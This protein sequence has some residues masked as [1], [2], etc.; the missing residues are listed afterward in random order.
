MFKT[1]HNTEK[2]ET[3]SENQKIKELSRINRTRRTLKKIEAK[4]FIFEHV[5]KWFFGYFFAQISMCISHI[6]A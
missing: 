3:P 4:N 1:T 2:K 6:P 5:L